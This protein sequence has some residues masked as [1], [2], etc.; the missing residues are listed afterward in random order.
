MAASELAKS[1]L[2]T[3]YDW[4]NT[5]RARGLPS[6]KQPTGSYGCSAFVSVEQRPDN[7]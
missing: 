2:L 6:L 5:G 4:T 1:S 3:E 7:H